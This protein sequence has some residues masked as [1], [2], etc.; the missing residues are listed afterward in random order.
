MSQ[1]IGNLFETCPSTDKARRERV[2]QK[3]SPLARSLD[4]G[5]LQS[6]LHGLGDDSARRRGSNAKVVENEHMPRPSRRPPIPE[7]LDDCLPDIVRERKDSATAGL[8]GADIEN[9]CP[10]IDVFKLD[11]GHLAG[12]EPEPRGAKNDGAIPA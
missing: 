4:I 10:P 11:L 5:L 7:V 3:V 2:P 8:A 6:V 1:E 9:A 12:T